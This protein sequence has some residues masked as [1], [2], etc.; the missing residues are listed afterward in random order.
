M[1]TPA[2]LYVI[3]V[4][5]LTRFASLVLVLAGVYVAVRFAVKH[6]TISAYDKIHVREAESE[7]PKNGGGGSIPPF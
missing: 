3:A 1:L 7:K 4:N 6:G 5:L 2:E